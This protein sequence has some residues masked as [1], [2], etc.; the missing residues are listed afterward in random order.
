MCTFGLVLFKSE[1]AS[2]G[3]LL[4]WDRRVVEKVEHCMGKFTIECSFRCISD[5][6]E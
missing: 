6:F 1:G 4:V 5:N 2:K 3:I